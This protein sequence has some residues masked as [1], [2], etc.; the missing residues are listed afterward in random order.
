MYEK[1]LKIVILNDTILFDDAQI[2]N[3]ILQK[4]ITLERT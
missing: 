4:G 2:R 3:L 1:Y